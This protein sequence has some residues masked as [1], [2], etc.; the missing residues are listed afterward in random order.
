M[1]C[2][3]WWLAAATMA[4]RQVLAARLETRAVALARPRA[5]AAVALVRR[6]A[7]LAGAPA[8]RRAAEPAARSRR[9]AKILASDLLRQR[10]RLQQC[11]WASAPGSGLLT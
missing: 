4:P 5:T 9:C 3:V 6:P 2:S 8:R 10:S 11:R 7:A 1:S